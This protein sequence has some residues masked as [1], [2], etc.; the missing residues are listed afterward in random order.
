MRHGIVGIGM[1]GKA[2]LKATDSGEFSVPVA[3]TRTLAHAEAFLCSL[4][5]L[6]Q[7]A[8]FSD[9][10]EGADGVIESANG[11]AV[12]SICIAALSK[13]ENVLINSCGALLERDD[14]YQLARE[15]GARIFVPP[16]AV[17]GLDGVKGGAMGR[18]ESITMT[19]RKPPASLKGAACIEEMDID[20]ETIREPTVIYEGAP[21]VQRENGGGLGAPPLRKIC[22]HP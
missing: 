14:L 17:I 6:P 5:N 3:A 7:I 19:T 22:R 4:K 21:T 18:L 13:G 20:V 9:V 15:N 10:A 8:G 2:V 1:I 11:D 16:G 12:P